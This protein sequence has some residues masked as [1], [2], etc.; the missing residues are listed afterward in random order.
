MSA[1]GVTMIDAIQG[2]PRRQGPRCCCA[3]RHFA[4]SPNLGGS[5]RP[6]AGA[7]R[8]PARPVRRG[9]GPRRRPHP[10]RPRTLRLG[11][12]PT[13]SCRVVG[14]LLPPTPTPNWQT[15]AW[16]TT[17]TA[18]PPDPLCTKTS[19]PA[20][21]AGISGPT[22]TPTPVETTRRRPKSATTPWNGWPMR[23]AGTIDPY[24]LYEKA[25][26]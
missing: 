8:N 6:T 19:C 23:S 26:S 15:R 17:A 12:G 11:D 10:Q 21:A 16:P 4:H 13:R 5:A 25:A 7:R 18:I 1:R 20:S 9:R 3:R 22:S 14:R 2:P 24:A